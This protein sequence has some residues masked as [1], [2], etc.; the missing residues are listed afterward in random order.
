MTIFEP[1]NLRPV[2]KDPGPVE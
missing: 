1:L 2:A